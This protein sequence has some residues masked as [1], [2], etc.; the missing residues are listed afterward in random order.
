VLQSE[1][2]LIVEHGRGVFVAESE[3]AAELR[4]SVLE[5]KHSTEE[6]FAMREV[7]EVPAA[8]WAAEVQNLEALS[9]VEQTLN[10]LIEASQATPPDFSELQRL[11]MEFHLAIVRASGN[12][13]LTQTQGVLNDILAEGMQSTLDAPGR[14]EQSRDE[15]KAILEAL[16]AADGPAAAEAAKHHVHAA[17]D[18]A[19]RLKVNKPE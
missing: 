18:T 1:G 4:R 16:I 10:L 12:R 17:R 2:R 14:L 11:D 8:R 15:H 7:L 5:S 13:F 3:S 19:I 9:K 6:L